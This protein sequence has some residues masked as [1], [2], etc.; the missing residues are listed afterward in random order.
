MTWTQSS[1]TVAAVIAA[2]CILFAIPVAK[3]LYLDNMDFPAVAK[4]TAET[5][6]PVYYRGEENPRHLGLY[7]PPLYIY[8][9]AAWFRLWGFG[10]VQA[11]LFGFVLLLVHGWVVLR[12]VKLLFGAAAAR[13]AAPWFW[14]LFLLSPFALQ[15]AAVLDIDTTIYGPLLVSML[16]AVLRLHWHDG[17]LREDEPRAREYVLIA[18]WTAAAFWAKLTTV[19]AVIPAALWLS[20]GG[21]GSR[22]TLLRCSLAVV[23]GAGLFLASYFAYG[24]LTGL[25]VTYTFRFTLMSF[26]G[27]LRESSL[28]ARIL[29]HAHTFLDMASWQVQWSGL[30]PWVA[31]LAAAGWSAGVVVRRKERRWRDAFI[32]LALSLA[33]TGGYCA[34]LYTFG[35]SPFKYVFVVWG[36]VAA[37]L[38][39]A[40]SWGFE[41]LRAHRLPAQRLILALLV[42]VF[43]GSFLA[44]G[45]WLRDRAILE[46]NLYP[47]TKWMLV[48]PVLLASAGM[49]L[50]RTAAGPVLLLAGVALHGG[51]MTGTALAMARA[52]YPT[53]YD[54]GQLGFEETACFLRENTAPEEAVISMKDIGFHTGRRYFENYGYLFTGQ[55]GADAMR[56]I[57]LAG[58]ARFAVFTEGNGPD[59]LRINP[60]L[61]EVIQES[62]TLARSY[63]H[64]RIYDC[65][66]ANA[67]ARG[68][69][70]PR[71]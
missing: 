1:R 60:P 61:Q 20:A 64:Y 27:R 38:S 17:Q 16:V 33:V 43:A 70:A 22:R 28:W 4:A 40:A 71:P 24:W 13:R 45:R 42:I 46:G 39:L 55:Q 7:H 49:L 67:S 5:G 2:A 30:L 37:C 19:L 65:A 62:C 3:P 52:P 58:K 48:T 8:L 54:Y 51:H 53:T 36:L 18:A 68:K 41:R 11:R 59:D 32:L 50:F 35:R 12:A 44:G 57:L 29:A 26:Q 56:A 23:S 14:A 31:A 9:L 69:D 6:L 47:E 21:R 25:D 34:L 63:G 10:A 15:G 66:K